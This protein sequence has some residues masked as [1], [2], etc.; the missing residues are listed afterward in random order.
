MRVAI[1]CAGRGGAVVG[2]VL[3]SALAAC[4]TSE[5]PAP[6]TPA[7]ATSSEPTA[8]A[9]ASRARF[10]TRFPPRTEWAGRYRCNQGITGAR[11][12]I[13]ARRGGDATIRFDFGPIPENPHLPE[14]AFELVGRLQ[15]D[16]AGGY[17]GDFEPDRWIAQPQGYVMVALSVEAAPDLRV[18]RGEIHHPDC[19]SF[20][21]ERAD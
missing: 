14:G 3:G 12:T 9:G 18:L 13:T 15:R 21:L 16:S 11:L 1:A 19:S 5:T 7:S 10:P 8:R 20:E 17:A 2:V 6:A 4:W